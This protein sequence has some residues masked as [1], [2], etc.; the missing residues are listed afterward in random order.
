M[1]GL[2]GC[3]GSA[4]RSEH[5]VVLA[6]VTDFQPS[7]VSLIQRQTAERLVARFLQRLHQSPSA[8]ENACCEDIKLPRAIVTSLIC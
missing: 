2:S 7:I 4:S 8:E 3:G 1:S 5:Q 6:A